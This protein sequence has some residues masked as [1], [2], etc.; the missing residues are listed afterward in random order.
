MGKM[1]R[2]R[3]PLTKASPRQKLPG[4]IESLTLNQ[5]VRSSVLK[6]HSCQRA[7]IYVSLSVAAGFADGNSELMCS[8]SSKE[9][10]HI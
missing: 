10:L 2:A 9:T 4:G 5:L 7:S 8:L 1:T 3:G 6:G